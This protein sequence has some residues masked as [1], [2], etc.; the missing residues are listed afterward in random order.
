MG[1]LEAIV[2]VYLRD[3]YYPDGFSFPLRM[4]DEDTYLIELIREV[5]TLVMLVG[6]AVL[7]ARS[8]FERFSLFLF[9]FGIWD[10][11]YYVALKI[12]LDWPESITEWDILF[13]IP[14]TWIGPVL[15]PLL[16]SISMMVM[17][18]SILLLNQRKR[19]RFNALEWTIVLFGAAMIFVAFVEDF[20]I[21]LWTA[22]TGPDLGNLLNDPT[23][24]NTLTSLIPSKFNWPLFLSGIILV[25][26]ATLLFLKRSNKGPE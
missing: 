2:V 25:N 23:F 19:Q 1:F 6:I 5:C 16:C 11:F 21:L 18:T 4:L 3:I 13:L 17:G 9:S 14:I 8:T 26:S 22:D 7:A 20:S 10:I 24:I 12:F 15:A